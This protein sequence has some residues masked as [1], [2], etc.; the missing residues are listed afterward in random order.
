[1]QRIADR[2]VFEM[3]ITFRRLP[4]GAGAP[5]TTVYR[6]RR[7]R[8]HQSKTRTLDAARRRL[9]LGVASWIAVCLDIAEFRK[10]VVQFGGEESLRRVDEGMR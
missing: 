1:M 8:R 3:I 2:F 10:L 5:R 7:A 9:P 6:P 4:A